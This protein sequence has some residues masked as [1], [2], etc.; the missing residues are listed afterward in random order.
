MKYDWKE[1]NTGG[2]TKNEAFETSYRI[3]EDTITIKLYESSTCKQVFQKLSMNL[4]TL[5]ICLSVFAYAGNSSIMEILL[6]SWHQYTCL[7]LQSY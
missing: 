1:K 5:F 7:E 6:S 4:I 2:V 3:T